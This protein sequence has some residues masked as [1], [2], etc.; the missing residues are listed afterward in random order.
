ML[1]KLECPNNDEAVVAAEIAEEPA[2]SSESA[3]LN[4]APNTLVVPELNKLLAG[5]FVLVSA[6][7]FAMDPNVTGLLLL[8]NRLLPNVGESPELEGFGVVVGVFAGEAFLYAGKGLPYF[9][10]KFNAN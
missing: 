4:P 7:T 8:E 5:S 1:E 9:K 10:A 3:Y 6:C 2:D